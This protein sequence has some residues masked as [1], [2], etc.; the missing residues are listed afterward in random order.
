LS[1][2]KIVNNLS[3]NENITFSK[4]DEYLL[5]SIADTV[6]T[7]ERAKEILARIGTEC[8]NLKCNKVLLDE[9]SVEKREVPPPHE[10]K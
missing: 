4:H 2:K 9:R 8:L 1:I 6:I 10:I 3:M 5:T 7:V